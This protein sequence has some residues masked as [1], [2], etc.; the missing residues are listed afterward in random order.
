[1]RIIR[2]D[3]YLDLFNE[4]SL[5]RRG[6]RDDCAVAEVVGPDCEVRSTAMN[7]RR[8]LGRSGPK[9]ARTE[10]RLAA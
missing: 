7:R 1:M 6:N 9:S 4:L 8:Q 3:V 5:S 2:T 10:Q